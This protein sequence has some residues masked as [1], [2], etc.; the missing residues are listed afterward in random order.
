[1]RA[2]EL[3]SCRVAELQSCRVAELQSC[4][5]AEMQ[6]GG[7]VICGDVEEGGER[8]KGSEE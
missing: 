2:V 8:R 5:V 6:S 4:R 7:V 3:Q 1:M